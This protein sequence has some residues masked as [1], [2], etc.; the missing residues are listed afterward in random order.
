MKKRRQN[1]RPTK[2]QRYILYDFI[3]VYD[4]ERD[5]SKPSGWIQRSEK[6]WIASGMGVGM[7]VAL[8]DCRMNLGD[9][10]AIEEEI[11]CTYSRIYRT[12]DTA[13]ESD[14]T[15]DADA[16]VHDDGTIEPLSEQAERWIDELG[17]RKHESN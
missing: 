5:I 9:V 12:Y 11:I 4:G 2:N 3:V 8:R 16:V 1:K 6:S 13:P 10:V 7:L 14:V 17:W 15:T